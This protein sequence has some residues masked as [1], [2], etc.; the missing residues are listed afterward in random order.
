MINVSIKPLSVNEAWQGKRFKT[1]EY[2]KYQDT[3]LLI[4][5]KIVLPAAPYSLKLVF[6]FS[7]VLSDFDNPVKPFIDILQKRYGFNDRDIYEAIITKQ[8]VAKGKEFIQFEL[9]SKQKP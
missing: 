9:T 5:P 6:G 4:L 3:L 8:V 1:Q 7:N 2:R